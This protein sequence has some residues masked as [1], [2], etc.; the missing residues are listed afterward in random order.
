MLHSWFLPAKNV[1][2]NK[3]QQNLFT[4][5]YYQDL[6]LDSWKDSKILD[7]GFCALNLHSQFSY[8]KPRKNFLWVENSLLM[9][10]ESAYQ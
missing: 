7:E 9:G 2:K 5:K 3:Q 1:N 6:N 8:L 4:H 10:P